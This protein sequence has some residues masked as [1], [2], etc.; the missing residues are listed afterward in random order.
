V[1]T[2]P[3]DLGPRRLPAEVFVIS[4]FGQPVVSVWSMDEVKERVSGELQKQGVNPDVWRTE[5]GLVKV[6]HYA[7]YR[8]MGTFEE[9]SAGVGVRVT[10]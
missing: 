5:D 3:L 7:A 2:E 1:S 4:R 8:P 9:D 6:E 10:A